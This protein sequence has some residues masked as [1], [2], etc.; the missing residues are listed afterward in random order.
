VCR[1]LAVKDVEVAVRAVHAD[2]IVADNRVG[3]HAIDHLLAEVAMV[4]EA[5]GG[6][7]GRV[8]G[9]ELQ[10]MGIILAKQEQ[11]HCR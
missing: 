2:Y 8:A 11:V 7:N 4:G 1:D 6:S 10:G 5:C 3:S 9:D